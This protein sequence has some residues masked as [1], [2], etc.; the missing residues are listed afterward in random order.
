MTMTGGVRLEEERDRGAGTHSS[1]MTL[2]P[3]GLRPIFNPPYLVKADS[4]A[5]GIIAT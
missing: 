3:F 5:V 1:V 4:P 2:V